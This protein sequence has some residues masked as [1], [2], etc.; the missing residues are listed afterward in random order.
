VDWVGFGADP[1]PEIGRDGVEGAVGDFD[2]GGVWGFAAF[3][4]SVVGADELPGCLMGEVFAGVGRGGVREETR[5]ER[6]APVALVRVAGSD[7]L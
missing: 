7:P 6:V 3:D 5:G 2:D 4:G 1:V